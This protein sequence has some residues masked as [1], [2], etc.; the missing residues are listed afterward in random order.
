MLFVMYGN[1]FSNA[2][3][4]VETSEIGLYEVPMLLFLFGFGMGIMLAN[5]H[6]CG[7]MLVLRA[8]VVAVSL[9]NVMVLC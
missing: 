6:M 1:I 5:F 9:L 7:M 8:V 2:L 4:N 3:A